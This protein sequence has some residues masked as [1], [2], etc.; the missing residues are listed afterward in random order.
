MPWWWYLLGFL[1]MTLLAVQLNLGRSG[2]WTVLPY[3]TA[4]LVFVVLASLVWRH[5]RRE[6]IR[7]TV[8]GQGNGTLYVGESWLPFDSI[9]RGLVIPPSSR[10]SALGVRLDPMAFVYHRSWCPW[11][12]LIVLDDG[13]DPTPYWLISTQHP[14]E[15]LDALPNNDWATQ[16]TEQYT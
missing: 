14:T 13:D 16:Q 15:L 9:A 11:M 7:V 2:Y 6:T 3:I 10:R 12:V 1:C 4:G 5:F 8:D